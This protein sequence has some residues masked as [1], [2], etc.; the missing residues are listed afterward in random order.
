M[1]E[2]LVKL[3]EDALAAIAGAADRNLLDEVRQS[4]LGR[5]GLITELLKSV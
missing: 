3:R 1:L 2:E 4:L 5:K